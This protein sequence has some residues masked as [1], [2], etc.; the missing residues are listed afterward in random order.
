MSISFGW[1]LDIV[2]KQCVKVPFDQICSIWVCTK[3][4]PKLW[5]LSEKSKN[6]D[7]KSKPNQSEPIRVSQIRASQIRASQTRASQIRASQI[8]ASQIR[9]TEI[10]SNHRELHGAIF[11]SQLY[12][13]AMNWRLDHTRIRPMSPYRWLYLLSEKV[14]EISN[15]LDTMD[16]KEEVRPTERV[17]R[18]N[19]W[20]HQSTVN[21]REDSRDRPIGA[22]QVCPL[23]Q[24][25]PCCVICSAVSSCQHLTASWAGTQDWQGCQ[26]EYLGQKVVNLKEGWQSRQ[27]L[28]PATVDQI[29]RL[30]DRTQKNIWKFLYS[31]Q[32]LFHLDLHFP[33]MFITSVCRAEIGWK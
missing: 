32:L 29:P 15:R 1:Y 16:E 18:W 26:P 22:L 10:S 25:K 23:C 8:R 27:F 20:Q 6:F 17:F 9:A 31:L 33:K 14:R 4:V 11:L 2:E 28:C 13:Y 3:W 7:K 30:T 5:I 12:S 19:P 24:P 21:H